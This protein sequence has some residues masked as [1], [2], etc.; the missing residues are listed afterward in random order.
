MKKSQADQIR[1]VKRKLDE[2]FYFG[3]DG[4]PAE[5]GAPG[6]PQ[7]KQSKIALFAENICVAMM[8]TL[9]NKRFNPEIVLTNRSFSGGSTISLKKDLSWEAQKELLSLMKAWLVKYEQE[10]T[11]SS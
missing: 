8:F 6:E 9:Q 1:D 10:F 7:P 4:T 5:G 2:Y 3:N 11:L